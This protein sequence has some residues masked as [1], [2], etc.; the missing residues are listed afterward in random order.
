MNQLIY[1]VMWVAI[2][3]TNENNTKNNTEYRAESQLNN[4]CDKSKQMFVYKKV[5]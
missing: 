1:A 5:L 2:T 3:W 4:I